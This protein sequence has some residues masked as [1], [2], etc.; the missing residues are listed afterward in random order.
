[1][2]LLLADHG[3]L[4]M[5]YDPGYP[6]ALDVASRG[7][8]WA[9]LACGL[10]AGAG[11]ALDCWRRREA[12]ADAVLLLFAL[13]HVAV[14]LVALPHLPGN[15]RYALFL[16]APAA[17]WLPRLLDRGWRRGLLAALV[18]FGA[19]GSLGQ[20]P[21]KR[22]ADVRWRGFVSDLLAHGVRHCYTDYYIAARLDFF[23]E[24]RLICSA[25]LG[26]TPTDYF[27]YRPRVDAAATAALIPV[28]ATAG[29]KVE[30]RLVRIGVSARRLE[31]M[32]P[33]LLPERKVSPEEIFPHRA[34]S[35]PGPGA[36]G[37]P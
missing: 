30:R 8:A 18:A 35:A 1:L 13:V 26:P 36:S 21:P 3:P 29:D 33:V 34:G 17:V 37:D 10:V 7:L 32:K 2:W 20:Y 6:A 28:N 27:E 5:G 19:L 12:G 16:A 23:S 25:G 9:G 24:E 15:A 22:Q 31:L 14:L 11:V 4:L